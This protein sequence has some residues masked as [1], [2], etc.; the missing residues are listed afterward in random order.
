MTALIAGSLVPVL[1][2]DTEES[3]TIIAMNAVMSA[4]RKSCISMQ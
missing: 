1:P 4:I 2:A 3:N